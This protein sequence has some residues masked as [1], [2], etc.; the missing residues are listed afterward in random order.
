MNAII[1]K[2]VAAFHEAEQKGVRFCSLVY[3]NAKGEWAKHTVIV[4][5]SIRK[6]YERDVEK[7][8]AFL[9]TAT[10]DA[11]TR[12]VA[13]KALESKM[14][15]LKCWDEGKFHPDYAHKDLYIS[16][17]GGNISLNKETGVISVIALAHRRKALSDPVTGLPFVYK[18]VKHRTNDPVILSR[19]ESDLNL[20]QY[21]RFNLINASEA[22]VRGG[23]FRLGTCQSATA[24]P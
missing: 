24:T 19:L 16:I 4:G 13:T 5:A 11:D 22:K 7:L 12:R 6:S 8:T 21:R 20:T 3:K 15:S 9:T 17:G 23:L 1:A 10:L 14:E 18:T 2:L